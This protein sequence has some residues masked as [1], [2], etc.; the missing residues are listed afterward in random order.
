MDGQC[1]NDCR[2]DFFFWVAEVHHAFAYIP[3]FDQ[4]ERRSAFQGGYGA[5]TFGLAWDGMGIEE[6]PGEHVVYPLFCSDDT[7]F[8]FRHRNSLH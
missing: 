8:L 7:F 6:S 4:T 5:L 2:A 3:G 1:S